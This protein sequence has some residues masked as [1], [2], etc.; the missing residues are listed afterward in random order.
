ML[1]VDGTFHTIPTIENYRAGVFVPARWKFFVTTLTQI[2]VKL[3]TSK[4]ACSHPHKLSNFYWLR[5]VA[6]AADLDATWQKFSIV[7]VI[8]HKSGNQSQS[9][10]Q[11]D[12]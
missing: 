5:G 8:V 11:G 12:G 7:F 4:D 1:I 10:Q 6:L 2:V 9:S 3:L